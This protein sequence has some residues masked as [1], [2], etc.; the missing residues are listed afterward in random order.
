MDASLPCR[1]RCKLR[2]AGL[3]ALVRLQQHGRDEMNAW[4]QREQYMSDVPRPTTGK[5]IPGVCHR[6]RLLQRM[7]TH[8]PGSS[9]L[10]ESDQLPLVLAAQQQLGP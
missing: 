10:P 6:L 8:A 3:S 5:N 1:E 9:F 4:T 2:Q 7:K